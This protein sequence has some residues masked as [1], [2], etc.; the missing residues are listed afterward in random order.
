[1][2]VYVNMDDNRWKKYKIDFD[3]I[4]NAVVPA[5]YKKAEVSITLVNDKEI[6][7]IRRT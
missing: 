2:R 1:M 3:K 5:K 4:A 6:Q 7:K